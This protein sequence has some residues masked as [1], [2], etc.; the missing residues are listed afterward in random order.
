MTSEKPTSRESMKKISRLALGCYPLGGGYGDVAEEDARA[1][2]DAAL[3]RGWTFF[4]TAEGY[5]LSEERLGR[6]L[7]GRRDEVFLATK[8]F[9]CEP[10]SHHNLSL[11][12]ESSLRRLQT[13][14]VDLF[15]LH[16]PEDWV[17]PFGPT[18]IEELADAL[19]R[20][21]QSGRARH[22][23]VCNLPVAKLRALATHVD[24]FSTQNLFSLIDRGHDPDELHL[25]VET[26]IMPYA[27]DA[28]IAVLAYSPLS[29]GLLTT[30]LQ[31]ARTFGTDDE[32][33]VLPR[34]QPGVYEHY[35]RLARNL[36]AWS[37]KR[38]TTVERVAVAW[39]LHNPAV[40][41]TLVGAK[42]APQVHA[43]AGSEDLALTESD[44]NEL[45][46]LVASLPEAAKA[47][48]MTVWDHVSMERLEAMSALRRG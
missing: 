41:S 24:L 48:R 40:A 26:E 1:T 15:Q 31:P 30:G 33:S 10:Y 17:M 39:T 14:Y 7:K 3:E 47:A 23:G 34:F 13:D 19:A 32:R 5:G 43:I 11:A 38:G 29:R 4:D 44:M 35:V 37:R 18:P 21:Q 42:S 6:I 12:L 45:E 46:A 27:K 9:P 16:G 8:A 25:P 22:V 20:L 36:E 2:V 28:G